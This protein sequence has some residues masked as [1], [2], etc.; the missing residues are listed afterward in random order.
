[1]DLENCAHLWKNPGYAPGTGT[2]VVA[3]SCKPPNSVR[4]SLV[5]GEGENVLMIMIM[6]KVTITLFIHGKNSSVKSLLI[7]TNYHY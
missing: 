1:M 3:V 6:I 4:S 2:K 5:G 7:A